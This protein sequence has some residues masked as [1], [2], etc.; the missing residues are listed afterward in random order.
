M[1][2]LEQ[3][4]K[5]DPALADL[6][7]DELRSVRDGL[8]GIA[9]AAMDG[10]RDEGSNSPN[11]LLPQYLLAHTMKRYDRNKKKRNRLLSRQFVRTD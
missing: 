3:C 10:L 5:I 6:S 9:Y 2:S 8:Y 1:L 4:R 7:D 11:G